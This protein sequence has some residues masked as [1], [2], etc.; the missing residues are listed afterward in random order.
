MNIQQRYP[1]G[2]TLIEIILTVAILG[3]VASGV[4]VAINPSQM[5]AHTRDQVRLT[6]LASIRDAL[7]LFYNTH[8][9]KYAPGYA[10]NGIYGNN[11]TLGK[12]LYPNAVPP[13]DP[14]FDAYCAT[15]SLIAEGGLRSIPG[16]NVQ[17][18]NPVTQC[19]D[20]FYYFVAPYLDSFAQIGTIQPNSRYYIVFCME[21]W[22]S[23]D[24]TK[25]KNTYND[26]Q[27]LATDMP[28]CNWISS[29]NIAQCQIYDWQK[30]PPLK[31]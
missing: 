8:N 19:K 2:F 18:P 14:N 31:P 21:G 17:K 22:T 30:L 26:G 23:A 13:S 28:S 15:N 20:Y 11:C 12:Y 6:N 25:Y 7:K 24:V 16:T 1:Q 29:R 27:S 4:V 9:G 10:G 5:L 3:V